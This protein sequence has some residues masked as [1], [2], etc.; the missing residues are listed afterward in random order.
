MTNIPIYAE[1]HRGIVEIDEMKKEFKNSPYVEVIDK[2]YLKTKIEIKNGKLRIFPEE[3]TTKSIITPLPIREQLKGATKNDLKLPVQYLEISRLIETLSEIGLQCIDATQKEGIFSWEDR[4]FIYYSFTDAGDELSGRYINC[5]FYVGGKDEKRKDRLISEFT[6]IVRDLYGIL[7]THDEQ[8][9]EIKK[10]E[11]KQIIFDVALSFAG[12]QREYVRQVAER[13]ESQGIKVFYDEFFESQL[14][15]RN[16]L[17][18]LKEVYYSKSDYCIM[19]ISKEYTSKM[20]PTFEGKCANA[21]DLEEFGDY[22]L[23]VEFEGT[24]MPGLDPGKKYLSASK[25][26]PQ[27]VADIFI[28]RFEEDQAAT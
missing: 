27:Q 14:W 4:A 10:K 1:H 9:L 6:G 19:F 13:L 7:T 24:K 20:W 18:Y 12:E 23:P 2:V 26:T 21:K 11:P 3:L 17:D 15:G 22:I 8:E 25:Y 5:T 28:K 16:L